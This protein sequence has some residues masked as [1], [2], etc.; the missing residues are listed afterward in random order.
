MLNQTQEYNIS[1]NTRPPISEEFNKT[2]IEDKESFVNE[3]D[4][5][6]KI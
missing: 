4:Q 6:L 1:S 2:V 3:T 5:L